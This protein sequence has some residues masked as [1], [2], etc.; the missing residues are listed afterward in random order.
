MHALLVPRIGL[1]IMYPVVMRWLKKYQNNHTGT[2]DAANKAL[3][4]AV[5]DGYYENRS[6]VPLSLSQK[7]GPLS[8]IEMVQKGR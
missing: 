6:W 7:G 1:R 8:L 5:V 4:D 2:F 3:C